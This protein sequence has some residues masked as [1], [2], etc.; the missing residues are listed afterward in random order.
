M[1][2]LYCRYTV[3]C[4]RCELVLFSSKVP[5]KQLQKCYFIQKFRPNNQCYFI[6]KFRPNNCK[7]DILFKSSD[8]TISA[9]LFKSSDLT[10]AKG[11]FKSSDLTIGKVTSSYLISQCGC[12]SSFHSV[13]QSEDLRIYKRTFQNRIKETVYWLRK[14]TVRTR[15]LRNRKAKLKQYLSLFDVAKQIVLLVT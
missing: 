5:T 14:H 12:F 8:L 9:I 11:L 10:I 1:K 15:K 3:Q 13:L 7:S 4:R 2:R 6:Q